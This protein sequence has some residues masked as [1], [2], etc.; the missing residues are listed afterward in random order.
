MVE[1]EARLVLQPRRRGMPRG[2]SVQLLRQ[3]V[4]RAAEPKP[5]AS[6]NRLVLQCRGARLR[7]RRRHVRLPLLAGE[8]VDGNADQV[9]LRALGPGLPRKG[10]HH[11]R[12][13]RC[14]ARSYIRRGQEPVQLRR[15]LFA[16]GEG[17]VAGEAKGLLQA[18]CPRLHP[19]CRNEA[20]AAVDDDDRHDHEAGALPLL[21]WQRRGDVVPSSADALLLGGRHRVRQR[22]RGSRR[23]QQWRSRL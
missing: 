14:L 13:C 19:F 7:R 4:A 10:Q 23:R 2:G 8:H 9:V 5:H 21:G 12:S 15:R 22:P 6:R 16:V 11:R 20:D 3:H 17:V 1:G 18:L